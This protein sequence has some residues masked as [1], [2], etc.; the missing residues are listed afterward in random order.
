MAVGIA[1]VSMGV[2]LGATVVE[3]ATVAALLRVVHGTV[4]PSRKQFLRIG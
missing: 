2:V 1:D 4:V 3:G